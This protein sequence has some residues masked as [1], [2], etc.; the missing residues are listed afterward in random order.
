LHTNYV[1]YVCSE[2]T[3]FLLERLTEPLGLDYSYKYI[4]GSLKANIFRNRILANSWTFGS[5][6]L[7]ETLLRKALFEKVKI[8]THFDVLCLQF[9][10]IT[11]HIHNFTLTQYIYSKL[12]YIFRANV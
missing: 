7:G 8:I 6:I 10:N 9:G 4:L 2:T 3:D 11:L 12:W 5:K 1:T